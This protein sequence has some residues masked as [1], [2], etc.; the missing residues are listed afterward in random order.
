[1]SFSTFSYATIIITDD[2]GEQTF[3]EPPK[4]V[5]VLNWDL[6]EQVLALNVIP[7]AAPNITGYRQWVVQPDAPESIKEIGTRSEPNLE[8]IAALN[9]DVII[10]TST[11]H[12]IIPIL[13]RIAPVVYLSNFGKQRNNAM[14]SIQHFNTLAR[15]FGKEALAKRKLQKMD[16]RFAELRQALENKFIHHPLQTLPNVIVMRFSNPNSV[17]LYTENSTTQYVVKKLGLTNPLPFASQSW[18]TVQR[19]I[20]QLQHITDG[21]VLYVL[22]FPEEKKLKTSLLWQ[23]LPF[24]RLGHVNSVRSVW[25]YGGAMS[26]QY[27]AEAITDSL[28]EIT[29]IQ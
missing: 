6:L 21:Y 12:D 18:G 22:P 8:K 23:S 24:V 17:F 2:R 16:A 10:A 19:R 4:R 13:E 3:A 27:M 5:V 9:P 15:L 11:Q 26:L 1:M 29:P 7:L 14:T 28:L 25:S 20:N